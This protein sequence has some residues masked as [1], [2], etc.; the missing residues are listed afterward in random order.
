[1]DKGL[2]K[3]EN[4]SKIEDALKVK[5]PKHYKEFITSSESTRLIKELRKHQFS[6]DEDDLHFFINYENVIKH[7]IS[8]ELPKKKGFRNNKIEIG[9]NGGGDYYL[10]SLNPADTNIYFLDHDSFLEDT[11]LEIDKETHEINFDFENSDIDWTKLIYA[12][13]LEKFFERQISFLKEFMEEI[14]KHE[15][16]K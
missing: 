15:N 16:R 8:S 1:M 9:A 4:L 12:T 3:F 13:S 5:L 14:S 10:I 11:G 2:F 7:N 6:D